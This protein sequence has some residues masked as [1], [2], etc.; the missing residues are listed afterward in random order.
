M[1]MEG[2]LSILNAHHSMDHSAVFY[3]FVS[4]LI[5]SGEPKEQKGEV[6]Q[7]AATPQLR[8]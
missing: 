3:F 4:S 2:H 8:Q 1:E 5:L 6:S 7:S